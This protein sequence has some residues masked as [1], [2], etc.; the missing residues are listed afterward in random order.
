MKRN[1]AFILAC[2]LVPGAIAAQAPL[3]TPGTDPQVDNTRYGGTAAQFL[4]LPG[5]ARGAALGGSYAALVNDVAAMFWNPAGLALG[6]TSQAAFSYTKYVADTHHLWAGM[7]TPLKGGEWALGVSLTNF[8]FSDQPVYTEDAQ[9]GTGDDYSVSETAVGLTMSLQFSDRFSA[10]FTGKLIS[11]SLANAT[12]TAF[13]VD[14]GT[15][16]HSNL[17]GRPIRASFILTNYG[18]SMTLSGAPLNITIPPQEGTQNVEPQPARLR[19]SAF[20]PPTQFR[21]GVAYDLMNST[22]NRL[23]L[24]S[25]FWQPTDSDPGYGFAAEYNLGVSKG[26]NAALRG[27]YSYQGDNADTD[28]GGNF[29]QTA[30]ASSQ[31]DKSRW[32]GLAFGGGLAFKSGNYGIG[33]DY[34]YRNLGILPAVNM[35]SVKLGF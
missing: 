17:L 2:L 23:T 13:G 6:N 8:G 30:F 20:E 12:G 35:F 19:T 29:S 31:Q 18:T 7:S 5:D 33:L 15:N 26:F 11:E 24:L 10:G 9:E 34:A 28:V 21:V 27:S 3:T 16:Y 32:D 14:F 22:S 4:T 25:E 1:F